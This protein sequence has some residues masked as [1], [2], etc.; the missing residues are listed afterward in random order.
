MYVQAPKYCQQ[1]K[2]REEASIKSPHIPLVP[3]LGSNP[4]E[5]VSIDILELPPSGPYRYVLAI[6][7]YFTKW[8]IA[9]PLQRRTAEYAI[10]RLIEVFAY[11]GLHKIIHSDQGSNLETHVFQELRLAFRIQK[12]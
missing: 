11:F 12:T 5:V 1:C 6:Q 8:L 2:K 7:A 10:E 3:L 9:L 4:W